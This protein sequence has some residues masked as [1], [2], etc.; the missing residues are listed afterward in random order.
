MIPLEIAAVAL[1]L[2]ALMSC[3]NDHCD[4][5]MYAPTN[6]LFYSEMDTSVSVEPTLL[7]LMGVGSDS[8]MNFSS[9][10]SIQLKLD[11]ANER[12]MFAC[13]IVTDHSLCDTLFEGEELRL[14]GPGLNVVCSEKVES[15]SV[16]SLGDFSMLRYNRGG[17]S[18]TSYLVARPEIDTLVFDYS[19]QIEFV[20]AECGCL[21]SHT[22]KNVKFLHNGIGSISVVDSSVTNLSDAKNVKIYLE[23]Y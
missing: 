20:S 12:C 9:Q 18:D 7:V 22:L 1:F 11:N 10:K 2:L 4:E 13:A 6:V 14:V 23:N 19:N 21:V 5:L 15:S 8:V 16:L 17:L 3:R